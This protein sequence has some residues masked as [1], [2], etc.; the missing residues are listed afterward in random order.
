MAPPP[1]GSY[2]RANEN[3]KPEK[4][5][6]ASGKGIK[7]GR[8]N[9]MSLL[10]RRSSQR[11]LALGK[12]KGRSS[13]DL[14]DDFDPKIIYGT[15][16]PDWS[17]HPKRGSQDPRRS[18]SPVPVGP[19]SPGLSIKSDEKKPARVELG[20][21]QGIDARIGLSVSPEETRLPMLIPKIDKDLLPPPS[22]NPP[23][24][25]VE[26]AESL[27]PAAVTPEMPITPATAVFRPTSALSGL[28]GI[29]DTPTEERRRRGVTLVDHPLAMPNYKALNSSRFSFEGSSKSPSAVPSQ[30]GHDSEEDDDRSSFAD[31]SFQFGLEDEGYEDDGFERANEGLFMSDPIP[32]KVADQYNG[33]QAAMSAMEIT[34][35]Q[36]Q[37]GIGMA[38]SENIP[39]QSGSETGF[40]EFSTEDDLPSMD[41]QPIEQSAK[42]ITLR[43]RQRLANPMNLELTGDDLD[44]ME[45][46]KELAG[47]EDDD[48]DMY[49]D[50]GLITDYAAD[51][52]PPDEQLQPQSLPQKLTVQPP[53]DDTTPASP[54]VDEY[55][56][57]DDPDSAAAHRFS[58]ATQDTGIS[59]GLIPQDGSM[60]TELEGPTPEFPPF[61]NPIGGGLGFTPQQ[62][63]FYAPEVNGT[64][65]N[66]YALSS[67]TYTL[68]QYQM[69]QQ[70]L[71]LAGAPQSP[72]E[73]YDSDINQCPNFGNDS[74]FGFGFDYD[75]NDD[76]DPMVA[77][78]N[79]EALANDSEG[80]YG[81]EFGFYSSNTNGG[82]SYAGGFFGNAGVNGE[83]LRPPIRKPSLTPISERSENSY[84]NS[85]VFPVSGSQ[86]GGWGPQGPLSP[87]SWVTEQ[88]EELTLGQLL[89]LRKNAWGGSNGSMRSSGSAGNGGG[90]SP[91]NSPVGS[92][93]GWG[94]GSNA[95]AAVSMGVPPASKMNMVDQATS[96][97]LLQQ[98]QQQQAGMFSSPLYPP[99]AAP[100]TAPLAEPSSA[101]QQLIHQ[102][103]GMMSPPLR[104][105]PPPP[106]D[107]SPPPGL[108][109]GTTPPPG[110]HHAGAK[111]MLPTKGSFED[112]AGVEA[113]W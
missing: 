8:L 104:S 111:A 67:L 88:G 1:V 62:H 58:M 81:S 87:D 103:L 100:I 21:A 46:E 43:S 93:L 69:Q 73:G 50:D 59:S 19:G 105:P 77:A 112:P 95:L 65:L 25:P 13:R 38:F 4:E 15:R 63:Q 82:L 89:Q 70:Q 7:L 107:L 20:E 109:F 97:S 17:S 72:S 61:I 106:P 96:Q 40:G 23:P 76:D 39:I 90:G 66:G 14:P 10:R 80:F 36:Q 99:S 44:F 35:A 3:V 45:D 11:D 52:E 68:Q 85:L 34:M 54:P 37:Q 94:A 33:L 41:P 26:E 30:K 9:P 31:G 22:R 108:G 24:P 83:L 42:D 16:H 60:A 113:A 74:D 57:Q 86:G 78:A 102:Y 6:E 98:P 64:L 56:G 47:Y 51:S 28:S 48:D 91:V 18:L 84:R 101:E 71:G 5:K 110:L 32:D 29:S 2:S 27:L 79:A 92:S 49:F 75:Y 55:F 53:S 12:D